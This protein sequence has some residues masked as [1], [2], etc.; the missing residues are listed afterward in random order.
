[1]T[2]VAILDTETTGFEKPVLPVQLCL[3]ELKGDDPRE[4]VLGDSWFKHFNPGKNIEYG[5]MSTHFVTNEQAKS[6]PAWDPALLPQV[7]IIIG[8]SIDYDWEAVGSPPDMRRI[9]TFAMGK[10]AWPELD[11]HKQGAVLIHLLGENEAIPLLNRAHQADCDALNNVHLVRALAREWDIATWDEFWE[12]SETCRIP[13]HMPFGKYGPDK[14]TKYKG[15]PIAEMVKTDWQYCS[16][17]LLTKVDDLDPYLR[18]AILE[19]REAL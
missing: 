6:H 10:R 2:T 15:M 8:H 17:F 4:F 5:A 11:S 19:A 1:M 13:T 12:L 3:I 16:N 18:R 7:D 14:S 9:C